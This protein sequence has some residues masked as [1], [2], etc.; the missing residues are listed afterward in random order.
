MGFMMFYVT[1]CNSYTWWSSKSHHKQGIWV[2]EHSGQTE[3]DR[4]VRTRIASHSLSPIL[5]DQKLSINPIAIDVL[6]CFCFFFCGL[7]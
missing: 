7:L 2:V 5:M 4:H 1:A 6:W 3:T